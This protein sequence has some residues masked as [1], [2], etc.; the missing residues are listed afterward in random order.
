MALYIRQTFPLGLFHATRWRENPF[1]DP[2]G[3]W[4]PS[5]WR[6]LRTLAKRWFQYSRETGDVDRELIDNL[7]RTIASELPE[8]YLPPFAVRGPALKQYQPTGEFAWSDPNAGS[9]AV[10]QSRTTLFPDLY[11]IVNP[12]EPIFWRWST[13]DLTQDQ[14]RLLA[15]LLARVTYFGRAESLSRLSL[16]AEAQTANCRRVEHDGVPVLCPK[17]GEPL[18]LDSLLAE[19]TDKPPLADAPVPPGTEWVQY[20]RPS[21]KR[22]QP[23]VAT[24]PKVQVHAVQ[25]AMGADLFPPEELWIKI[26]ER[27]RGRVLRQFDGHAERQTLLAGKGVDGAPL[28]EHQHA[29]Y[30]VWPDEEGQPSRLIVW[31]KDV[32]FDNKELSAM[33]RA[34]ERQIAWSRDGDWSV[35]LVPMPLKSALPM[36]FSAASTTWVSATRFVRPPG[37]HALRKNG[38]VR[39]DES[40]E[41]FCRRLLAK[42]WGAQARSVERIDAEPVWMKLHESKEA[43]ALRRALGNRTPRVAPGYRLLIRFTEPFTGPLMVGDSSHF[44][45]GLFRAV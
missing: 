12:H 27:F 32:P 20:Q 23:R 35:R 6:L 9:G 15:Q 19:R 17:A 14:S 44:G 22:P 34:V 38:K 30:I 39:E 3:E 18:R 42:V 28:A 24:E 2:H 5:P 13:V 36:S 1:A 7:L 11:F 21:L 31:R 41:G 8:F 33:M 40:V 29:Y 43:R 4:P 26:T 25:F 16:V 10:K 45:I 37:R